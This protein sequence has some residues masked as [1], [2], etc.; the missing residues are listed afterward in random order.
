MLKVNNKDSRITSVD[1]AINCKL[2]AHFTTCLVFV[3]LAL[4]VQLFSGQ[5]SSFREEI[6]RESAM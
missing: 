1:L 5:L 6:H 2:Y 4:N 3:L